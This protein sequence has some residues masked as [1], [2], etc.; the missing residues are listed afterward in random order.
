MLPT[1]ARGLMRA[2]AQIL[3]AR[4]TGWAVAAADEDPPRSSE[5]GSY[6]QARDCLH[7]HPCPHPGAG[8]RHT[9]FGNLFPGSSASSDLGEEMAAHSSIPARETPWTE[10]PGGLQAAGLRRAGSN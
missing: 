1:L 5:H 3:L 6:Q 10:E 8:R 2:D 4:S 9:G 7:V